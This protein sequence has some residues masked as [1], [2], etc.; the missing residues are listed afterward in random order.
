MRPSLNL[1]LCV[2]GLV[3]A[4]VA[5]GAEDAPV[6]LEQI[7]RQRTAAEA[8]WQRQEEACRSRFVVQSCLDEVAAQRRKLEQTLQ[9]QEAAAHAAER[10]QRAQEQRARSEE[11]Q[12][13]HDE[14]A[15][16][17]Q[18]DASAQ[19]RAQAQRDKVSAHQQVAAAHASPAKTLPGRPDAATQARLREAY[20]AKQRAANE[21]RL[22]RDKRLREA[23]SAPQP[24]PAP[25]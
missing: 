2:V 11:K 1:V 4:Q 9:V 24:L 17:A 7:A 8:E 25:R 13:A 5:L 6:D 3:V 15:A 19:D 20:M 21:R 18:T 10:Q 22:A 23:N 12:R 14:R 16:T